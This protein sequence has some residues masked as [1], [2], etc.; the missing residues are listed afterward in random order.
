MSEEETKQHFDTLSNG[1]EEKNV[2]LITGICEI[3]DNTQ[4]EKIIQVSEFM[5]IQNSLIHKKEL[6]KERDDAQIELEDLK[7]Q[8]EELPYLIKAVEKKI[9]SI[10]ENIDEF[11]ERVELEIT[12]QTQFL[13][14]FL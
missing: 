6:I 8:L 4:I 11:D 2:D 9:I 3:S 13:N 14:Q 12:N 5:I 7:K 1:I 10:N